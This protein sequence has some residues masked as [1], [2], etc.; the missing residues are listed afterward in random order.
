MMTE[1][2]SCTTLVDLDTPELESAAK[3][4]GLKRAMRQHARTSRLTDNNDPSVPNAASAERYLTK[5]WT[6]AT[7]NEFLL[8]ELPRLSA[9]PADEGG[10]VAAAAAAPAAV[11]APAAPAKG[12][13]DPKKP[14]PV[15]AAAPVAVP[16][17]DALV[18][19]PM[20]GYKIQC[21][22]E[23]IAQRD[24]IIAAYAAIFQADCATAIEVTLNADKEEE[25]W[26][27]NWLRLIRQLKE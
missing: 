13:A 3:R 18:S 14:E 19:P 12:K 11:P 23:V 27:E 7:L 6:G 10:D 4:K 8:P 15:A 24:Q 21:N 5:T 16:A 20:T 17:A 22:R 25:K 9:Q 2:D 26:T 1:F